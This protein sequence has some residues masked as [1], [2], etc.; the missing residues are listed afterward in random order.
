MLKKYMN[1]I[2][3][4]GNISMSRA[5]WTDGVRF[6]VRYRSKLIEVKQLDDV[7]YLT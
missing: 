5:I 2:I 4:V 1:G 7:W 6:F 3:V